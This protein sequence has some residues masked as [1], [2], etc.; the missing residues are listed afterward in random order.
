MHKR[1]RKRKPMFSHQATPWT[2]PFVIVNKNSLS[3]SLSLK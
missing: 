2:P 1:T 3:L